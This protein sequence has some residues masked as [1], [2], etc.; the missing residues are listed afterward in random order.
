MK[1]AIKKKVVAVK[2]VRKG[3]VVTGYDTSE[4]TLDDVFAT[5]DKWID[6]NYKK[7]LLT[8]L[9][10]HFYSFDIENEFEQIEGRVTNLGERECLIIDIEDD[11]REL[12]EDNRDFICAE[13]SEKKK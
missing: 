1:K 5:I 4:T 8:Q 11:V 10:C 9:H 13:N 3:E 12:K 7:G 2:K 6:S